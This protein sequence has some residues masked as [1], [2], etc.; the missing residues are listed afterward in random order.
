[1]GAT[2]TLS[3]TRTAVE[4]GQEVTCTVVIRN[5]GAVVDQFV[6]DVVGDAADWA[7]VEPA[8]VNLMPE[9]FAEVT[10][11]FAPPRSPQVLAGPMAFAV[12]VVSHEDPRGTAVEEGILDIAPFTEISVE[13][14]PAKAEGS[15][16]ANYEVA[17]DNL[18]NHP[19]NVV[20]HLTDPED[21]LEFRLGHTEL[22]LQPGT[23][24]FVRMQVRPRKRFLRGQPQRRPFQAQVEVA[25]HEPV[26]AEGVM[27]QRQLLPKW[28]LPALLGLLALIGLLVTLWFTLLRPAVHSAAR[29]AVAQETGT[30]NQAAQQA[31]TDAG[32]AKN[33]AGAAQQKSDK[34]MRAVGLDP[35]ATNTG[36]GPEGGGVPNPVLA[37]GQPTDFR[38]ATDATTQPDATKFTEFTYTP[39]DQQKALVITDLILQNPRG[40]AGTLRILRDAGGTKSVLLEVGLNNFRDL[41]QHWLQPW[42]FRPGEKVV[43]AVSCQ[44][45]TNQN[46]TPAVSFSGRVT[47]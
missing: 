35:N 40:D 43:L 33:D 13:V 12:R 34:A 26:V 41:D 44:N 20:L 9:E 1:M 30:L 32:Q 22:Q 39:P 29:D 25:D 31:K 38:I 42:R 45:L 16:R 15:T 47:G 23:A 11:R 2:A 27:I 21:D 4:P 28:L 37:A 14:V 19:A 10:V 7:V 36:A 8:S 46:C 6:I 17:V 5:A 18:G 3:T 24:A